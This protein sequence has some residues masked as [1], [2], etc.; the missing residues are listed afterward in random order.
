VLLLRFYP[1]KVHQATFRFYNEVG[2]FLT[3]LQKKL[4]YFYAIY[5][6]HVVF[7]PLLSLVYLL[8]TY[9]NLYHFL[10]VAFLESY[11]LHHSLHFPSKVNHHL[12]CLFS[13]FV[14]LLSF[15]FNFFFYLFRCNRYH[16]LMNL[17]LTRN[18]LK[19]I[20]LQSLNVVHDVIFFMCY[21]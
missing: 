20:G 16:S 15:F 10:F 13:T 5:A 9:P 12:L 3:L 17:L 6:I 2:L 8:L 7:F 4:L 1:W 14:F 11:I 18:H 19:S 21:V